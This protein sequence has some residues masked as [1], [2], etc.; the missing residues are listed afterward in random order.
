MVSSMPATLIAVSRQMIIQEPQH[1]SACVAA[2]ALARHPSPRIV[3][4]YVTKNSLLAY[5]SFRLAALPL[6]TERVA[7]QRRTDAHRRV[8]SKPPGR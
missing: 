6:S 8:A 5:F 4:P 2:P 1:L 7:V 3:A